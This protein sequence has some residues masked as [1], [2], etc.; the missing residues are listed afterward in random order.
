MEADSKKPQKNNAQMTNFLESLE[1]ICRY[2]PSITAEGAPLLLMATSAGGPLLPE[3]LEGHC[4]YTILGLCLSEGVDSP[5]SVKEVAVDEASVAA[6]EAL[7]LKTIATAYRKAALREHP[8]KHKGKEQQASARFIRVSLAFAFLSDKEKRASY[9]THLRALLSLRLQREAHRQRWTGE[10]KKKNQFKEQLERREAAARQGPQKDSE[11]ELLRRIREENENLVKQRQRDAQKATRTAFRYNSTQQQQQQQQQQE[12]EAEEGVGAGEKLLSR[13]LLFSWRGFSPSLPSAGETE[14]TASTHASAFVASW[15]ASELSSH[16][17]SDLSLFSAFKKLA[18][19]SFT[20]RERAIEAALLLQ[21]RRRSSRRS[22]SSASIGSGSS[23]KESLLLRGSNVKLADKAEGFAALWQ[24]VKQAA[25]AGEG[26]T[27]AEEAAAADD[28]EAISIARDTQEGAALFA[29]ALAAAQGGQAAAAAAADPRPAAP[30]A[31]AASAS[32]AVGLGKGEGCAFKA[33]EKQQAAVAAAAAFGI[34]PLSGPRMGSC[35]ASRLLAYVRSCSEMGQAEAQ[36]Q[37][38][39]AEQDSEW[40]WAGG[41]KVAAKM[42][43]EQLE[44]AAFGSLER[45]RN[46]AQHDL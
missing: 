2:S 36:H 21:Q 8:D 41:S 35:A 23:S 17:A 6:R 33:A 1:C 29:A 27:A 19:V 44:A 18:C 14:A 16:G 3:G 12:E 4:P 37:Q 28:D 20:S 13:S 42:S 5:L 38:A 24:K 46:N 30:A 22:N 9:H 39:A 15:L 32:V 43:L 25:D 26:K 40:L 10:D 7:A 31:A 45:K 11:A 34:G